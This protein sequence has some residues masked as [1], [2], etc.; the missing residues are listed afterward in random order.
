MTPQN[1]QTVEA[2]VRQCLR[3][4]SSTPNRWLCDQCAEKNFPSSPPPETA[5]GE[6]EWPI[7]MFKHDGLPEAVQS[8]GCKAVATLYHHQGGKRPLNGAVAAFYAGYRFAT[9]SQPPDLTPPAPTDKPSQGQGGEGRVRPTREGMLAY[10]EE[11]S[12]IVAEWPQWKREVLRELQPDS[13]PTQKEAQPTAEAKPRPWPSDLSTLVGKRIV[14]RWRSSL[15]N[16]YSDPGKV[17]SVHGTMLKVFL[18]QHGGRNWDTEDRD[19]LSVED[20]APSPQKPAEGQDI[21]P[22]WLPPG[23]DRIDDPHATFAGHWVSMQYKGWRSEVARLRQEN[24]TLRE[25]LTASRTTH[26]GK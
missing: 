11:A 25:Q 4:D 5:K 26:G 17:M 2:S 13:P 10:M 18:D 3:C 19:L 15:V 12:R 7:S 9:A 8:A 20:V 16:S 6:G 21:G 14:T 22:E 1:P 23:V 24:Q